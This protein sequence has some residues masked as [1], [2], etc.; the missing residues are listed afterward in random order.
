MINR[1]VIDQ[2]YEVL[3]LGQDA[4]APQ[5]RFFEKIKELDR[6][7]PERLLNPYFEAPGE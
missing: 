4:T 7:N 1:A 6:S 3:E 2:R 5:K